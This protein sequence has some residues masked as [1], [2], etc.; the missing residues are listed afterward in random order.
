M[1]I[2]AKVVKI[3]YYTYMTFPYLYNMGKMQMCAQTIWPDF[4]EPIDR[5]T[6]DELKFNRSS[7]GHAKCFQG[8]GSKVT[9]FTCKGHGSKLILALSPCCG[10]SNESPSAQ[11]HM[12]VDLYHIPWPTLPPHDLLTSK[13]TSKGKIWP[14]WDFGWSWLTRGRRIREL[15][16]NLT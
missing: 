12:G 11:C 3:Y 14:F 5:A 6:P 9:L 7:L 4:H 8:V 2:E 15:S 10:T 16:L 13:L 1:I